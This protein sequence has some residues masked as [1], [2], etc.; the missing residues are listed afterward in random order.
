MRE[1]VIGLD[2]GTTSA[3]AVLFDKKGRL[4]AEAEEM[5]TTYSPEAD[6]KEQNPYEVEQACR[7][8]MKT[9][10]QKSRA[11][12]EDLLAVGISCAMH[13]LICLDEQFEPL[14]QMMIWSDGRSS[15]Q[16]ENLIK[17]NGKEIF[18]KTGTPIHPMTPFVKLLW[19]K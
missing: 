13:S 17:A 5:V 12:K 10:I 7:T 11:G 19:M 16:A 2:I 6:R 18:L 3:K 4:I 9:V 14:S 1:L 15:A 8:A